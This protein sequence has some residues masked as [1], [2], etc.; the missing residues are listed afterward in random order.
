MITIC[1]NTGTYIDMP[2]HRF[3]DGHDLTGLPLERVA[4]VPGVCIDCRGI[5]SIGPEHISGLDLTGYAVL[6]RTDHS[7][8]F[9]TPEYFEHHPHLSVATA[10][11][12]VAAGARA[13]ASTRST[14]MRQRAPRA[15]ADRC[16]RRCSATTSRS[17]ST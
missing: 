7:Q 14:S 16:T 3:V 4:D 2:Y 17:S 8:H 6:F 15:P 5:D 10:E 12:L 13:S 9:A 1:S 11:A